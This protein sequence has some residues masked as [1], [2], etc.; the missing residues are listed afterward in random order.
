TTGRVE[1][2][3][4]VYG[5]LAA[6]D[7][8]ATAG[9]PLSL[10]GRWAR[11]D[12]LAKN[13]QDELRREAQQLLADLAWGKWGIDGSVY[14]LYAADAVRWSGTEQR[15]SQT[16]IFGEAGAAVWERRHAL[17]ASGVESWHVGG[18]DVPVVWNT[19]DGVLRALIAGREFIQSQWLSMASPIALQ[20]SVTFRV[21]EGATEAAGAKAKRGIDESGLP[22]KLVV[23]R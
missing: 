1:E 16:E 20:H 18:Q 12:L 13:Q 3:L 15:L 22:G 8:V 5:Q 9:V 11:C 21:G 6:F 23:A 10:I 4:A 2:A 19:S 17:A 14:A 7:G